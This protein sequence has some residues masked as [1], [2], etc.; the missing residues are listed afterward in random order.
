MNEIKIRASSYSQVIM[1]REIK[2]KIY[3]KKFKADIIARKKF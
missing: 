2:N 1:V 3:S